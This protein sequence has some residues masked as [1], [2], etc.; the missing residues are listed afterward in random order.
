[1]VIILRGVNLNPGAEPEDMVALRVW[2]DPL[3]LITVRTRR[4]VSA[5]DVR[6][7]I[8]AGNG[9]I[10]PAATLLSLITRL[11]ARIGPVVDR[12]GDEIDDI[13]DGLGGEAAARAEVAACGAA[14][15]SHRVSSLSLSS[16]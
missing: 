14:A 15:R 7:E 13:E 8:E 16:T 1:M 5:Q 11:V 6:D 4:L 10:T 12:L 2:I 9:P 3:R